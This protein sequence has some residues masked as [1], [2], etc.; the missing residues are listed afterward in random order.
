MT[1]SYHSTSYPY[2]IAMSSHSTDADRYLLPV[3][4]SPSPLRT[5][6]FDTEIFDN[7]YSDFSGPNWP[8]TSSTTST[9][10]GSELDYHIVD[11]DSEPDCGP[12]TPSALHNSAIQNTTTTSITLH[13]G[14]PVSDLGSDPGNSDTSTLALRTEVD[15]T[16]CHKICALKHFAHWT[17][18]Q[19]SAATE[20]TLS[21][22]YCIAHPPLTPIWSHTRGRH[23][24][25]WTPQRNQLIDLATASAENCRKPYSEISCMAGLDACDWTL[26]RTMSSARYHR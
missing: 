20:V 17:Y 26:R 3:P 18:C 16:L 14:T 21:A 9:K 2:F 5:W 23:S 19:I 11:A 10:P 13:P 7:D 12:S 6:L 22:V 25:L 4:G 1:F 15:S 8:S 24:I